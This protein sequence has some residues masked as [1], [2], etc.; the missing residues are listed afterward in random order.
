MATWAQFRVDASKH[1]SRKAGGSAIASAAYR[2]GERLFDRREK[3]YADYSGRYGVVANGITMP[4]RGGPDWTREHLW[5]AAEAA[6]RRSDARIA[7]KIELAL[8]AEMS[9]GQRLELVQEWAKELASRYGVAVDWAIHLPDRKGSERNHHAHL[10]LTTREI[11]PEGFG[12]KAALELSNTQQRER[13]LPA[14]DQAMQELRQAVVDRYNEVVQRLELELQADARSYRERGVELVPT[15]HVGVAGVGIDRRGQEAE[16]AGTH[17]ATRELNAQKIEQRPELLLEMLTGKDAVFSR[18]DMAKELHRYIDQPQRFAA[19][20]ARLDASPELVRLSSDR[21]NTLAQ[22]STREMVRTEARMIDAAEAMAAAGRHPVAP[23]LVRATLDRHTQLSAEQR[24][25]VEHVLAPAQITAIV[26]SAG[27]GK[28][29]SLAAAREVW[30]GQGYRVL[31]AALAGKAAEELQGSAGMDSRTLAALEFAWRKGRERLTARDVLVIDEAGMVGSRQLGRV[32]DAARQ[33]GAKVVL[34]GDERQLQPIEAGAAFRAVIERIGSA[35][36]R[37]IWRPREEW[38]RK[39][40]QALARGD[41]REGLAAYSV[42]GHMRME[43]SRDTAK[44]AIARDYLAGA[45]SRLIMAHTNKDVR[46]LNDAVRVE[47]Q[48]AGGLTQEAAFATA[49]GVRQ[50]AA[51]DRVVFLANDRKLGVKNGTLGTVERAGPGQLVVR[52]DDPGTPGSGRR[53][54]VDQAAYDQVAHGY[55]VTIHKSQG[56]T[57]DRTFVLASGGMD[58]YLAYVSLTRHRDGAT[59]Y[60]GRDDFGDERALVAWLGRARPKMS[61]LDFAE[62]RGFETSRAW[63]D[64][65]RALLERG[66]ERLEQVWERAGQAVERVREHIAQLAPV[67][68]PQE[69]RR[70][71]LRE[72]LGVSQ[73]AQGAKTREQRMQEL[74]DTATPAS[75]A[76]N[77]AEELR[78]APGQE[79]AGEPQDR[80]AQHEALREALLRK[81]GQARPTGE[82]LRRAMLEPEKPAPERGRDYDRGRE[83]ER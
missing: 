59:L 82:E 67:R 48:R 65:A 15:R 80:A 78:Q 55:A 47:W 69:R 5:N 21:G 23:G 14:G 73:P 81:E 58:A 18:R 57:L 22:F 41:V 43:D 66:R 56:A 17:K 19:V 32:L 3:Q 11:G 60:A 76:G 61:T 62:R 36:V 40:S 50:F 53:V 31:G 28:S 45:G 49:Q 72:A 20:M 70:E 52:L 42:R 8:P 27:A 44:A 64:D 39:A 75:P 68:M 24:A 51:D 6:E 1:V 35:E 77:R 9:A 25:A 37:E 12:S 30:E 10:M 63:A 38:A 4:D 79:R 46:D 34:V 33:A 2:A 16:R 13:G 29:R 26:G 83:L 71:E 7:R 74:Q 54:A